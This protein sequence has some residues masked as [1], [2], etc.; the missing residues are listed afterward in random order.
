M[1]RVP[2][3]RVVRRWYAAVAPDANSPTPEAP[4]YEQLFEVCPAAAAFLWEHPPSAWYHTELDRE[5]FREL[6]LSRVTAHHGLIQL[7]DDNH[8]GTC[9]DRL[10]D[11]NL[12]QLASEFDFDL[13]TILRVAT[14]Y[15][16]IDWQEPIVTKPSGCAPRTIRHG[17][18]RAVGVALAWRHEKPFKALSVYQA[19]LPN[20]ILK[21]LKARLC[22]LILR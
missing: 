1:R 4:P 5:A 11:G 6:S 16:N 21:P 20:P 22:G 15:P 2:E 19:E 12:E 14:N 13:E 17:G 18:H 9:A 3:E 7:A 10:F 8:V